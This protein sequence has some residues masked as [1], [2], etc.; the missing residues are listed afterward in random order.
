MT[1]IKVERQIIDYEVALDTA[2]QA[3]DEPSE[4][5]EKSKPEAAKVIR[6]HEKL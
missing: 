6:M 4:V 5:V 1:R 2:D 3:V